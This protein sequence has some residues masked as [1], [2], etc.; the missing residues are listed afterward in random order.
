MRMI[1]LLSIP[2]SCLLF[3]VSQSAYAKPTDFEISDRKSEGLLFIYADSRTHRDRNNEKGMTGYT[4]GNHSQQNRSSIRERNEG[5]G[6]TGHT[7]GWSG[8]QE[9]RSSRERDREDRGETGY[10]GGRESGT[11]EN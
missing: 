10:T 11:E 2:F 7:G 8:S 5:D 6:L 9:N 3:F 4:G 1:Y